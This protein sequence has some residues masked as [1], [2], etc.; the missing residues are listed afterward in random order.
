MA[1][2]SV[3]NPTLLDLA[4]AKDPDGQIAAVVEL[5]EQQNE[6]ML[7]MTWKEGNLSTGHRTTIR[8]GLPDATW[9]RLYEFVQP[10]KSTRAQVDESTGM[11]EG[12]GEIDKALAD[13]N[14]LTAAFRQSED[15]SFLESM[16]Q[17][18][19]E[20]IFFGDSTEAESFIG[21][22]PRYNSLS[23]ANGENIIP[24]GGAGS[25]NRS[26]WL[27][28]WADETI[29][30]IVPKGSNAGWQMNDKGQVTL[31]DGS[32]GRMEA[33]Q[34]HYRWDAGICVRDWRYAVRIA[35]ID[36]SLLTADISTGANLPEL[37][38]QAMELIPNLGSVRPVF[39][40]SR[41]VRTF[42]RQQLASSTKQSV[43]TSEQV[44][45]IL[46]QSFHGIPMRRVDRLA[47]DEALV[48]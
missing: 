18:V 40:M 21:L 19:A 2:L 43:L 30:G 9:R 46:T 31:Y 42:V 23:A 48:S 25:D 17:N 15:K 7:D 27:L 22:T 10:S 29:F 12:Y 16:A 26:I 34:T 24:G 47:V 28:G 39:Y 35:N 13:L 8:T 32:G 36:R 20:K 1:T 3:A 41:D 33:Y 38:F 44:G 37:M 4:K 14:G 45:G 5:L 11:L 6:I